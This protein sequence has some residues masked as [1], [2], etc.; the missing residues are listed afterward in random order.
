MPPIYNASTRTARMNAV[1]TAIDA[2]AGPGTIEICSSGYASVLAIFTLNDPAG[3]VSGDTLTIDCDP[4]LT[5]NAIATGTA[6]IARIKD[7]SGDIVISGLTVGT[8]GTD[9]LISPS[10]SI[11]SGSL[12]TVISLS[13]SHKSS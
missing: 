5:T 1:L 4:D 9:I 10:T 11:E 7:N 6:A 3:A 2:D 8:S 12:V 13:F